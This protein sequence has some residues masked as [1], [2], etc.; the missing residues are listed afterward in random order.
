VNAREKI[1]TGIIGGLVGLGALGFGVR[2][3]FIKPLREI[4]KKTAP[5][6]K[7]RTSPSNLS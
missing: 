6:Q 1:L 5:R 7:P 3:V 4:D 2:T